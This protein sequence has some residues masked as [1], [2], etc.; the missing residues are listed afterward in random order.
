M[1]LPMCPIALALMAYIFV[2]QEQQHVAG[3]RMKR[4]LHKQRSAV[5]VS[6]EA[7]QAAKAW[8]K[9]GEDEKKE[10]DEDDHAEDG[11]RGEQEEDDEE[12]EEDDD[13]HEDHGGEEGSLFQYGEQEGEG[14][15]ERGLRL[16]E[17]RHD[18]QERSSVLGLKTSSKLGREDHIS[19]E[20]IEKGTKTERPHGRRRRR[21]SVPQRR[22]RQFSWSGKASKLITARAIGSTVSPSRASSLGRLLYFVYFPHEIMSFVDDLYVKDNNTEY[23]SR[24]TRCEDL[25]TN[26]IENHTKLI[27]L[28]E[29]S[30]AQQVQESF[31]KDVCA[32]RCNK[33]VKCTG[34]VIEHVGLESLTCYLQNKSCTAESQTYQK[35]WYFNKPGYCCLLSKSSTGVC[36]TCL[37]QSIAT[38]TSWCGRNEEN[39]ATCNGTWCQGR[40]PASKG[41]DTPEHVREI[42][43]NTAKY[44]YEIDSERKYAT[45]T[46][47]TP[48]TNASEQCFEA[49]PENPESPQS[50]ANEGATKY[51]VY[52]YTWKSKVGWFGG[53]EESTYS[54]SRLE[55]GNDNRHNLDQS[56]CFFAFPRQPGPS[57]TQVCNFYEDTLQMESGKGVF[58][59]LSASSSPPPDWSSSEDG[60]F[61][62]GPLPLTHD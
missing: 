37:P 59:H 10:E 20:K 18:V 9:N 31:V 62:F 8:E 17:L 52:D 23:W 34:I 7:I 42:H 19:L 2:I 39:C 26:A 36:P 48:S 47:K 28:A 21:R 27:L 35:A 29:V 13:D 50:V 33:N 57:F 38:D 4:R 32:A 3:Y 14:I 25:T 61:C 6:D 46:K 12:E 22:R 24:G 55:Q 56:F 40:A 44:C 45:I 41:N 60:R 58:S 15:G 1:M 5:D 30:D 16:M 43:P 11:R 54:F 49:F 53:G 51:C